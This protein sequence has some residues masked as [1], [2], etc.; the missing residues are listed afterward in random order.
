MDVEQEQDYSD[1]YLI[2]INFTT[3]YENNG[4][5]FFYCR[6]M[7][8]LGTFADVCANY[9][10]GSPLVWEHYHKPIFPRQLREIMDDSLDL[11]HI[12]QNKE[13]YKTTKIHENTDFYGGNMFFELRIYQPGIHGQHDIHNISENLNTF[14]IPDLSDDRERGLY[15]EFLSRTYILCKFFSYQTLISTMPYCKL[16]KVYYHTRNGVRK[17]PMIEDSY[18]FMP[19][20]TLCYYFSDD[21]DEVPHMSKIIE[22]INQF[23]EDY[24]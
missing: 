19:Y 15:R 5:T 8:D 21:D 13:K 2:E 7:Q 1:W 14:S 12:Y 10:P 9:M 3:Y 6:T 16:E 22:L 11:V 4:I 20:A 23:I 17:F 18:P 24:N